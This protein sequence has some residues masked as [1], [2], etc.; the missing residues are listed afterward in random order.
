MH[1]VPIRKDPTYVAVLE[2]TREMESIV[3]MLMNVRIPIRTTVTPTPCVPTPKV[4][5][6]V[7]VSKDLVEMASSA[8][9][10]PFVILLALEIKYARIS[11]EFL[12][13]FAK[14]GTPAKTIVQTLMSV[15]TKLKMTVIPTL[16]VP[17][18]KDLTF[19]VVKEDIL[20]MDK[21]AQT[22]MNA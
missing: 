1:C 14:M 17:T 21:I 13:V 3:Q 19:V 6:C 4:P 8:Q 22:W 20:E 18:L 9:K 12:N 10:S 11:V 2:D 5:M 7:A 15:Q 16:F